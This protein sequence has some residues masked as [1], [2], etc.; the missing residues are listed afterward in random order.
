M[1]ITRSGGSILHAAQHLIL[2]P[3]QGYIFERIFLLRDPIGDD[4]LFVRSGVYSLSEKAFGIFTAL[5]GLF[6]GY[7]G[8]T[9]SDE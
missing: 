2:V 7:G 8:V 9:T 1:H 6:Q 5:T 3:F 4:S